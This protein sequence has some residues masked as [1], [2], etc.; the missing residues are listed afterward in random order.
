MLS[1]PIK[2]DQHFVRYIHRIFSN[3]NAEILERS[4]M[5][6]KRPH[7]VMLAKTQGVPSTVPC[8]YSHTQHDAILKHRERTDAVLL[9]SEVLHVFMGVSDEMMK[10][11]AMVAM[12]K[13]AMEN[14]PLRKMVC[15]YHVSCESKSWGPR[16]GDEWPQS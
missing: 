10:S 5:L 2:I 15:L 11:M 3:E 14:R 9:S 4:E 1:D 12:N 7:E 6:P 16:L 13:S 8:L